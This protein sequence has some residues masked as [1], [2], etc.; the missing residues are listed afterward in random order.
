M[1]A[2][3]VI[4]I[5]AAAPPVTSPHPWPDAVGAPLEARFAPPAAC[6]PI[7]VAP[8][9]FAAWLRRLP[10]HP[11]RPPVRLFDGRLKD[12]QEAHEAVVAIDVGKRDLQQCADAVIRLRAEWLWARGCEEAIAFHFTSGDLARWMAWRAGQRPWIDGSR[13]RWV[14]GAV[15]DPSYTSF[16]R[17]LETVF[18]YAGS[19]S[20]AGELRPVSDPRQVEGGDVFVHA[21]HPGHAVVVVDVAAN[22]VGQRFFLL[23]QS[24]MPAQEI[25]VLRNPAH[26]GSPWYAAAASGELVTPEWTFRYT[27]LRR[28][29]PPTCDEPP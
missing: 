1:L 3:S 8:R 4:G 7:P 25:H 22:G 26:V 24:Y 13:V 29:E 10:L 17:Y 28:F 16:R 12:N 6:A 20:L 23:A 18:T 2:L 21:G 14:L 15:A 19:A 5:T 27:E 11:G 9:S